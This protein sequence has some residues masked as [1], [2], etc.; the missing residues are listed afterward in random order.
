G[1]ALYD[2]QTHRLHAL[3]YGQDPG[4]AC[5]SYAAHTLWMLGGPDRS[6]QR[7]HEALTLAQEVAHPLSLAYALS[8][9]AFLH[10]FRR[11]WPL[12]QVRAEATIALAAEQGFAHWWALGTILQ[13]WARVMQNQGEEGMAQMRQGLAAL[14]ATGTRGA[15]PYYLAM[16]AEAYGHSG[17]A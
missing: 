17:Q 7:S 2:R 1:I 6:L 13:G 15:W 16:L 14:Q 5:L 11:E 4:V 3:L 10:I 12:G 9:A 8:F